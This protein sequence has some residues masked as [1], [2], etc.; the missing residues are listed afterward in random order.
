MKAGSGNLFSVR[1]GLDSD[2]VTAESP[3][4]RRFGESVQELFGALELARV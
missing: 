4:L 3:A 2:A 1:E